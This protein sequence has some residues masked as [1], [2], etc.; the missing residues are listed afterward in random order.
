MV[1]AVTGLDL[2]CT[3]RAQMMFVTLSIAEWL[4]VYCAINE[5]PKWK[6]VAKTI[7][8][9][10]LGEGP[11]TLDPRSETVSRIAILVGGMLG[12]KLNNLALA[13]TVPDWDTEFFP[14]VIPR[15][16]D[17][18]LAVPR[19]TEPPLPASTPPGSS[20]AST[21]KSGQP[22]KSRRQKTMFSLPE[23][24]PDEENSKK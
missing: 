8:T 1:Y 16:S 2:D 24:S 13:T 17:A 7:E 21:A 14:I 11:V 6:A 23:N 15:P 9:A 19:S 22:S 18:S 20:S 12:E 4:D 10:C 5:S 3:S